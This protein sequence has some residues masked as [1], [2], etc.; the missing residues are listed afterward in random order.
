M[1]HLL[2]FPLP[3]PLPQPQLLASA[4]YQLPTTPAILPKALFR[5]LQN[6]EENLRLYRIHSAASATAAAARPLPSRRPSPHR[7]RPSLPASPI[8]PAPPGLLLLLA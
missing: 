7:R 4:L 2:L 3:P 8:H 5:F 6:D 1:P